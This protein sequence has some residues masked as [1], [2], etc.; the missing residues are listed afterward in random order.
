MPPLAVAAVGAAA[1]IGGALLSS[2]AQK[3]AASKAAN[4][5]KE[6]SAANNALAKE[7]MQFASVRLDPYAARGNAAGNA[8]NSLLGLS[9][10]A[11]VAAQP[12]GG[13]MQG[14]QQYGQPI[15]VGPTGG[16]QNAL[17]QATRSG[18]GLFGM[19][20]RNRRGNG[21]PME[22]E[23]LF[24]PMAQYQPQGY[25]YQSQVEQAP[26]TPAEIGATPVPGGGPIAT[27]VGAASPYESAFQNY[28][29]STGYQFQMDQGMKAINQGYAAKGALQSG[30]AMKALQTY[31]QNT[32]TSFFKDYLGLLANQQGVGLSG[33][34]AV[35]GV[36]QNYVNSVSAN[37]NAA[38]SA[39][40]NAALQSGNANA[41]MWGGI[42]G[43]IGGLANAFGSSY[44]R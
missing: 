2:S 27:A 44:R 20:I 35:A 28:L 36:G 25:S 43:S 22:Q 16:V 10:P 6:T 29:N 37:N 18:G 24:N 34:S 1:G 41:N 11:V 26:I 21:E 9:E 5:A 14:T 31:G 23:M 38:G 4:A 42:A 8:I 17:R 33:A 30:A 40:A 3:K 32:G 13:P 19:S 15:P 12:A 7:Q 39:A